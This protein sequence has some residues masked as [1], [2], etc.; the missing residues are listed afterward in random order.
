MPD[1]EIVPRRF[2]D[3]TKVMSFFT[4]YVPVVFFLEKKNEMYTRDGPRNVPLR[5]ASVFRDLF[6]PLQGSLEK[7]FY[8]FIY[9]DFLLLMYIVTG[10]GLFE[11]VIS[12]S[13]SF[14]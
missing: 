14:S 10:F 9:G 8:L 4:F 5:W 13:F 11:N 7:Y 1:V 3:P 12:V 2:S 6:L